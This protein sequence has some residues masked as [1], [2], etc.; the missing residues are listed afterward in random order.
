ME[1]PIIRA[2]LVYMDTTGFYSFYLGQEVDS[3]QEDY[4]KTL[5]S[6][7]SYLSAVRQDILGPQEPIDLG[8]E[9]PF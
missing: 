7:I 3:N 6:M 8:E 9:I 5:D 1:S 4:L 2:E